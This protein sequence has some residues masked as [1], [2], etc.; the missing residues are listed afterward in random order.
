M[1]STRWALFIVALFFLQLLSAPIRLSADPVPSGLS[2]D[3]EN[4]LTLQSPPSHHW[5]MD[6]LAERLQALRSAGKISAFFGT[7]SQSSNAVENSSI[8]PSSAGPLPG[9]GQPQFLSREELERFFEPNDASALQSIVRAF[10]EFPAEQVWSPVKAVN[11]A[12]PFI[13]FHQRKAGGSSLRSSLYHA[14]SH[15]DLS[16]F[17]P[18]FQ[19]VDCD[20]YHFDH[21]KPYA[22]YAG[23]FHWGEQSV[24]NRFSP[25]PTGGVGSGSAGQQ[26]FSCVTNYRHPVDRIES[27][28]YYRF[29]RLLEGRCLSQLTLTEL[30]DLLHHV[31]VY[32]ATCLNEPFRVMGGISDEAMLEH[33]VSVHRTH[34][35]SKHTR[36]LRGSLTESESER[37]TRRRLD[38]TAIDVL[39]VNATL[40]NTLR[41]SPLV[42]EL[43]ESFAEVARRIPALG[44]RGAFSAEV[45]E[46]VNRIHSHCATVPL[47]AEQRAYIQQHAL[48]ELVVYEAVYKKTRD[49]LLRSPTYWLTQT[50][51]RDPRKLWQKTFSWLSESPANISLSP[52]ALLVVRYDDHGLALRAMIES[53]TGHFL[54]SAHRSNSQRNDYCVEERE[55]EAGRPRE[56]DAVISMDPLRFELRW[57]SEVQDGGRE[58]EAVPRLNT[59]INLDI[60][61][62]CVTH[63]GQRERLT[64][65]RAASVAVTVR[66]PFF[67]V[68]K[69]VLQPLRTEG[70]ALQPM[71]DAEVAERLKTAVDARWAKLRGESGGEGERVSRRLISNVIKRLVPQSQVRPVSDSPSPQGKNNVLQVHHALVYDRSSQTPLSPSQSEPATVSAGPAALPDPS[72]L[73]Q[74]HVVAPKSLPPRVVHFTRPVTRKSNGGTSASQLLLTLRANHSMPVGH[75]VGPVS[76]TSTSAQRISST[77]KFL[78]SR[79]GSTGKKILYTPPLAAPGLSLFYEASLAET[80]FDFESFRA[81]FNDGVRLPLSSINNAT[82]STSREGLRGLVK[83]NFAPG[84]FRFFSRET[85]L[86]AAYRML[87]D[88]L[89]PSSQPHTD[90]A[91]ASTAFSRLLHWL[92][93]PQK[94]RDREMRGHTLLSVEG[95][96]EGLETQRVQCAFSMVTKVDKELLLRDLPAMHAF[97]AAHPSVLEAVKRV[98]RE[99]LDTLHI[100]IDQ[101]DLLY[102]LQ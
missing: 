89:L 8:Y 92:V 71:S 6:H 17:I 67:A 80:L 7:S 36:S 58:G 29:N 35:H 25:S 43:P 14:A 100:A 54:G 62:N 78:P 34:A 60:Q 66:D 3:Q 44:N 39:L 53:A 64:V 13:F 16:F 52:P 86:A 20:T 30:D 68:W 74:V 46:N 45:K 72:R 41:C 22:V 19:R 73:V 48:L 11:N 65:E 93:S 90:T 47:S 83:A 59:D 63:S 28:L 21:K 38:M 2:E 97:Y 88:L 102:S 91:A 82:S 50:C 18:C 55:I 49:R 85:V 70:E 33:L 42:L 24:F 32:G 95:L 77:K 27:C 61:R 84:H 81:L 4:L 26:R 12:E 57:V 87:E 1:L 56:R 10:A 31:D 69:R 51:W 96:P 40:Q 23:H 9:V 76:T 79:A 98:T 5:V 99:T 94:V 101:V 15:L 75:V 37:E